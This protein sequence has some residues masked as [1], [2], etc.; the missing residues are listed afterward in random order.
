[1]MVGIILGGRA[2]LRRA[3]RREGDP[4]RYPDE[5]D[6]DSMTASSFAVTRHSSPHS[7]IR[8]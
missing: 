6:R 3:L 8:Q 7:S 4:S 2:R 5:G 1:L